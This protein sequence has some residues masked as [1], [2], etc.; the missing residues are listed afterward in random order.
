MTQQRTAQAS[1]RCVVPAHED[2]PPLADE[3]LLVCK[4]HHQ[5]ALRI[6]LLLPELDEELQLALKPYRSPQAPKAEGGRS[7]ETPAA[8]SSDAL[9]VK[10]V[11]RM[12]IAN[13]VSTVALERKFTHPRNDVDS[14]VTFLA[15]S[16]QW[17]SEHKH[18]APGWYFTVSELAHAARRAAF[19]ARPAGNYLGPCPVARPVMA[20]DGRTHDQPC[21]APVRFDQFRYVDD[22][23]YQVSCPRCKTEGSLAWWT[24]KIVGRIDAAPDDQLP[25]TPLAM[26]LSWG[27]RRPISASTVRS[28]KAQGALHEVGRDAKNRPL[29]DRAAAEAHARKVYG[30]KE[31]S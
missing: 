6:L 29:Y 17:L 20:E 12:R 13:M 8:I 4:H 30:L 16:A 10:T 31:A 28:W 5:E 25:A 23:T 1:Q 14:M 21:G 19:E 15:D 11:L 24:Q 22:P 18:F 7:N 27:L 3:G 26:W 9:A 2:E